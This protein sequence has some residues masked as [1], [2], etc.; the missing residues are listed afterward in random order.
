MGSGGTAPLILNRELS[1]GGWPLSSFD[2]FIPEE[3]ALAPGDK[4]TEWAPE[5]V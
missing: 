1:G 5:S 3:K 4:E 2:P